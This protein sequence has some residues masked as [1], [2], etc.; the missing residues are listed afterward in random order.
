MFTSLVKDVRG[1]GSEST[2]RLALFKVIEIYGVPGMCSDPKSQLAGLAIGQGCAY[3]TSLLWELRTVTLTC[4]PGQRHLLRVSH[5]Q[6]ERKLCP[7]DPRSGKSRK[8]RP[9][10]SSI[11]L[12]VSFS[13]GSHTASFA[14]INLNLGTAYVELW[15]LPVNHPS[16]QS[17][18]QQNKHHQKM[19]WVVTYFSHYFS[20]AKWS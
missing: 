6:R 10:L 8:S 11:H 15:V 19:W 2:K 3:V 14:V 9:D 18:D 16:G 17:W 5:S 12:R 1:S 4:F 13:Y 20:E 7:W